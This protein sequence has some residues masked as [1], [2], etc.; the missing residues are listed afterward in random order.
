MRS[1][2][3]IS[4]LFITTF[5]FGQYGY[6]IDSFNYGLGS[7]NAWLLD[8]KITESGEKY[9]CG[10]FK[11]N[12][13]IGT[14][15]ISTGDNDKH[16]FVARLNE[17]WEPIWLKY[18]EIGT[19]GYQDNYGGLELS[20]DGNIYFTGSFVDSLSIDG[21]TI[22]S[23]GNNDIFIGKISS[24]GIIQSLKA[25]GNEDSEFGYD[26]DVSSDG[27]V[28][29]I[30]RIY[31]YNN[32]VN[33][34]G[35]V[36]TGDG[37]ETT[38]VKF[39]TDLVAQWVFV[40]NG[41]QED[42][43]RDITV[44]N[45]GNV[46]ITGYYKYRI[47][48]GTNHE[49]ESNTSY[50]KVY[51]A[52]FNSDGEI[53][54]AQ[55]SMDVG[56]NY[57]HDGVEIEYYNGK[58]LVGGTIAGT[59]DFDGLQI[60]GNW[61]DCFIAEYNAT[62]GSIESLISYGGSGYEQIQAMSI[63]NDEL[64]FTGSFGNHMGSTPMTMSLGVASVTAQGGQASYLGI[65][66]ISLE[67]GDEWL[68]MLQSQN[69]GIDNISNIIDNNSGLD[70]FGNTWGRIDFDGDGLAE[71]DT[72]GTVL[73]QGSYIIGSQPTMTFIEDQTMPEDSTIILPIHA[74]PEW[75][76][77]TFSSTATD[78]SINHNI[79]DDETLSI[80]TIPHWHGDTDISIS[81]LDS[82]GGHDTTTFTLTVTPVN[83][84]PEEFSVIYPTVSDTFSTHVDSDTAIAFTWEESY[85]VDSDVTYTLTIELE[86]FGNTYTDVHENVSDTTV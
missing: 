12:L 25:Y 26:L 64:V 84:S 83:D 18:S 85:D 71:I 43:P 37:L 23:M 19:Y 1:K 44:D 9:I 81:C 40:S 28:Y 32:P 73:F 80:L 58:V 42:E 30:S 8:A 2:L 68:G 55:G 47:F 74:Q 63:V 11:G 34:D 4:I 13:T 76:S 67:S 10:W 59:A 6:G 54:W 27:Y 56:Q 70:L 45:N 46:Y 24:E 21:T 41:T 82:L 48:T 20:S 3:L 53:Q 36:V 35:I 31:N 16:F 60:T 14:S 5:G 57:Y 69:Y 86:F 61:Q 7:S 72:S 62:D 29:M 49:L 15:S 38:L 65:Y 78:S 33:F 22:T 17:Q 39:S 75:F 79:S 50:P 52:K 77:M 51:V 66:D